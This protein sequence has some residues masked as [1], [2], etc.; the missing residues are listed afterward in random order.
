M[1]RSENKLLRPAPSRSLREAI[2]EARIREAEGLDQSAERRSTELARLEVLK[3]ELEELFEELPETDDRFALM[4]VPST[5]ARL[6]I[7]LFCA[8]LF[9]PSTDAYRLV[10][11]GRQGRKILAETHDVGDMADRVTDYVAEQIVTRARE[12][13]GLTEPRLSVRPEPQPRQRVGLVIAAFVIG[14]LTGV[15]GLF[16]ISYLVIG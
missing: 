2:R 5:P 11:N 10:R 16:A 6:W 8:V 14:L 12:L 3:A 1:E 9:D 13:D 4:L 15:A 7:D